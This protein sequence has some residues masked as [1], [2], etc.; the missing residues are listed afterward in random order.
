MTGT[1]SLSE[2]LTMQS[3]DSIA[4]GVDSVG[5]VLDDKRQDDSYAYHLREVRESGADS[6]PPIVI[7][8]GCVC[9]GHHRIAAC[10]DLGITEIPFTDDIEAFAA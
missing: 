7:N 10:V 5:D 9:D 2:V 6:L 1:I 3:P 8:F 4:R